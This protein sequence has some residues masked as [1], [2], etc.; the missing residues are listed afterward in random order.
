MKT[1]I[2]YHKEMIVALEQ[3]L[4]YHKKQLI[5]E[6]AKMQF[7]KRIEKYTNEERIWLKRLAY[8]LKNKKVMND[9]HYVILS[10]IDFDSWLT[11][12]KE[13]LTP[14]EAVEQDLTYC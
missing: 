6:E 8:S 5:I 13:G 3:S 2:E 7:D 12:Q 9:N 10:K 4:T 14:K 11:Y 1:E